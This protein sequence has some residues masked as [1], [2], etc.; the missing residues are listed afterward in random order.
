MVSSLN[1]FYE[2]GNVGD[3][4][5]LGSICHL[6]LHNIRL[7]GGVLRL[8]FGFQFR[9]RLNDQVSVRIKLRLFR[10]IC[11]V[12]QEPS[13]NIFIRTNLD[14][15]E[16]FDLFKLFQAFLRIAAQFDML[17]DLGEF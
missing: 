4:G 12:F 15:G 7:C 2:F 5:F 3:I 11:V 6:L 16:R 10:V 14:L 9:L 8:L 1:C 17:F 13:H